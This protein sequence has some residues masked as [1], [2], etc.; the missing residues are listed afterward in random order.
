MNLIEKFVGVS[1][2]RLSSARTIES[3]GG[4]RRQVRVTD[5]VCQGGFPQVLPIN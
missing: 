2:A 5:G 1:L 3:E 4:A